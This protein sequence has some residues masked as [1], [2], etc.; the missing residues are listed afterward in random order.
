MQQQL[1]P[2]QRLE[3]PA[4]P[5]ARFFTQPFGHNEQQQELRT[6]QQLHVE[7]L[8]QQQLLQQAG[9]LHQADIRPAPNLSELVA[10]MQ[11]WGEEGADT[12]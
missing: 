8:R 6:R 12:A 7:V 1:L 9:T 5:Q 3:Q 11:V 10:D 2:Q 4:Q